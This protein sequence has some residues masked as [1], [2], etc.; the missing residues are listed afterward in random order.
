VVEIPEWDSENFPMFLPLD[1]CHDS[2]RG[3][4]FEH[5][6]YAVEKLNFLT[7]RKGSFLTFT[8]NPL[9]F[10]FIRKHLFTLKAIIP[11]NSFK[12]V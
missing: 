3:S 10:I 8:K 6:T 4:N 1:T 12:Q 5:Y 2:G 11:N 9:T 7:Y